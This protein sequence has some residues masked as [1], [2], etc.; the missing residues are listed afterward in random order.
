MQDHAIHVGCRQN[1]RATKPMPI[2]KARPAACCPPNPQQA[3][4]RL[5]GLDRG[6]PGVAV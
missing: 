4:L 5:T 3:R 1:S 6:E 2:G